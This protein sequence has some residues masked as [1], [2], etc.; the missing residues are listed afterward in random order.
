FDQRIM[1]A[2]VL[3]VGDYHSLPASQ[4]FAVALIECVA[5]KSRVVLGVEAVLSRD[6]QIVDSW[7]RRGIDEQELRNRIRFDRELGYAWAPFYKLLLAARNYGD[8]VY[9]LDCMPR[10]DLR[11]IRSRD[12]HA[13]AK[14]CE[15]RQCH[16]EATIVVVFGESHMAPE[17]LPAILG[18]LFPEEHLL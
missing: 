10:D 7:W 17:H 4:D 9:G 6:Q 16:P 11:S 14:I 2:S 5:Q 13:A 3:L 8:G 15:I 12:R 1:A 18:K